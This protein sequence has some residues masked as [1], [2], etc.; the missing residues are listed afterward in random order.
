MAV[1]WTPEKIAGLTLTEVKNLSLNAKSKGKEEVF[2]LCEAEIK[3]R[4]PRQAKQLDGFERAARSALAKALE[5]DAADLLGKVA[6]QL[7]ARF[8]LSKE[9]ARSL[10]ADFK[11]FTPHK[12]TDAK[13]SAK[14]GGAQKLGL[15]V[16]DRYI[17][18]R[19][20][21]DIYALLA[22]LPEGDNITSVRYQ[23]SGPLNLLPNARPVQ[24]VR[25]F[26]PSGTDFGLIVNLE[27]FDNFGAAAERFMFLM[28]QVA[29]K[30]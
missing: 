29:P 21:N 5:V 16:F 25:P 12:L 6:A 19:L 3:S 20:G 9:K 27:D 30:R 10:S 28:E 1:T 24:D 17:S 18:Y 8:D 15:V 26:L 2:V 22:V 7:E 13:G 11:R 23:V 14:V 4:K